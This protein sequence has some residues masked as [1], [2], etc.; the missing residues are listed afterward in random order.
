MILGRIAVGFI[1][2]GLIAFILINFPNWVMDGTAADMTGLVVLC[3]I[4]I[5]LYCAISGT[6][7]LYLAG[8]I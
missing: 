4:L 7:L 6:Y 5:S 3:T 2:F 1:I 8:K